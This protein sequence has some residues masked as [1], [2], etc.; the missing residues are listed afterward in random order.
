[1]MVS[2][3]P[4]PAVRAAARLLAALATLSAYVV[5]AAPVLAQEGEHAA[6]PVERRLI[7]VGI[8]V[9]FV[10]LM[11]VWAWLYQRVNRA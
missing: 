4:G 6:V 5:V 7:A 11:I 1:M 3:R 2:D 10:A 9:A 8:L